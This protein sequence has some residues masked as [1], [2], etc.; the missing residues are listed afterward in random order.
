MH[1]HSDP[2]SR[3]AIVRSPALLSRQQRPALDGGLTKKCE[4]VA[5]AEHR[6]A[7]NAAG[8]LYCVWPEKASV[9]PSEQSL[10]S[11]EFPAS[12]ELSGHAA[13]LAS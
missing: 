8:S 7:Q 2:S 3:F 9:Q 5:V 13:G 4:H 11:S 6:C 10:T 12:G 1:S